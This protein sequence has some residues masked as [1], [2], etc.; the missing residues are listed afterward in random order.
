MSS[1]TDRV[2]EIGFFHHDSQQSGMCLGWS[3]GP[4]PN[5][6]GDTFIEGRLG[7]GKGS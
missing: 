5:Q 3:Q 2:Q 6:K 4:V 7:P 1:L